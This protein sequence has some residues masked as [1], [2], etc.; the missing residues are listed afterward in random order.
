[1]RDGEEARQ[2]QPSAAVEDRPAEQSGEPDPED[3]GDR[4]PP[5]AYDRRLR[6]ESPQE[7]H[8]LRALPEHP[9]ERD[10]A[11][12][13]ELLASPRR[14]DPSFD[15][16]LDRPGV[17]PHPPTVPGEENHGQEGDAQR[18]EVRP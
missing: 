16:A 9:G 2:A 17:L 13:P 10:Q 11:D 12:D 14:V 18:D 6:H 8:G 3:A 7:E 15:V 1:R 4:G 5:A